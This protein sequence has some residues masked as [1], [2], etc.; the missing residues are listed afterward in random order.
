MSENCRDAAIYVP[1]G[2]AG[3]RKRGERVQDF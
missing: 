2:V 1:V 3:S